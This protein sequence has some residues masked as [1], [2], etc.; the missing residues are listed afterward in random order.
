MKAKILLIAA[1]SSG[2]LLGGYSNAF[3]HQG[4]GHGDHAPYSHWEH[5]AR[6]QHRHHG[7]HRHYKHHR[8]AYRP[9]PRYRSRIWYAPRYHDDHWGFTLFYR[10]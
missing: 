1:I 2:L 7:H 4:R 5:G 10:E 9:A 8:H 3:A 6:H